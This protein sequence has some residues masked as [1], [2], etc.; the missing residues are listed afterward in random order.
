MGMIS[1]ARLA[2]GGFVMDR[3]TADGDA[4]RDITGQGNATECRTQQDGRGMVRRDADPFVRANDPGHQGVDRR[5]ARR[6]DRVGDR[7]QLARCIPDLYDHAIAHLPALRAV[8]LQLG[9]KLL[10]ILGGKT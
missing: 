6:D 7:D 5:G 3:H 1:L 4:Q 10:K 8:M 9:V 2:A